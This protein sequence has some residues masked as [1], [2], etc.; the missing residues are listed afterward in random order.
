MYIQCFTA[1]VPT[2]ANY[3]ERFYDKP[4][5]NQ[6]FSLTNVSRLL[7]TRKDTLEK[8]VS[9]YSPVCKGLSVDDVEVSRD[10]AFQEI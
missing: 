1:S 4:S 5:L 7:R 8:K 9:M 10:T 6:R 2:E 3:Y